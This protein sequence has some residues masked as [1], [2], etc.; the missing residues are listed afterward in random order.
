MPDSRQLSPAQLTLAISGGVLLVASFLPWIDVDYG[1]GSVTSSAWDNNAFP[2]LT[3]PG[4]F[5]GTMA[6]L[7]LLHV[8]A[9]VQLPARIVGFAWNE[10]Q[11]I[12]AVFSLLITGSFLISGSEH[13]IGFFLSLLASI[14][15]VVGAWM[16]RNEPAA[17]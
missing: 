7:T 1:I 15:L 16:L 9:G 5:G 4:I 14:G 3:W 2:L 8:L 6:V 11:L 12:A 17:A 13:G 10:I